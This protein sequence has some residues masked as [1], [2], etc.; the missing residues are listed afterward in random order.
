MNYGAKLKCQR[1]HLLRSDELFVIVVTQK[2]KLTISRQSDL[3]CESM[4]PWDVSCSFTVVLNKDVSVTNS[5]K[6]PI[7]RAKIGCD[8]LHSIQY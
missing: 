7:P 8:V 4:M 2:L 3:R 5:M 6:F 1:L